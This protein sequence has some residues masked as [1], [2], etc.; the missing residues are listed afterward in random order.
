MQIS[1]VREQY[2]QLNLHLNHF[3]SIYK[4]RLSPYKNPI[5]FFLKK[6]KKKPNWICL[7]TCPSLRHIKEICIR[8][9]KELEEISKYNKP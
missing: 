3:L 1:W 7:L 5:I 9:R 8:L 2:I 4:R 6:K